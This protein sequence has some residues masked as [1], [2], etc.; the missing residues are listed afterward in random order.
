M[1]PV[2]S[3]CKTRGGVCLEAWRHDGREPVAVGGNGLPTAELRP[4]DHLVRLVV[5]GLTRVMAVDAALFVCLFE[6]AVAVESEAVPAAAVGGM[7]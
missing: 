3:P 2:W 4:G 1:T 6:P 5:S 7:S